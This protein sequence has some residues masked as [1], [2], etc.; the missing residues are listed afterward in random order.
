MDPL[1]ITAGV[2]GGS[3]SHQQSWARACKYS[4]RSEMRLVPSH[5]SQLNMEVADL[6]LV[7][8]AVDTDWFSPRNQHNPSMTTAQ[9]PMISDALERAKR[10]MLDVEVLIKRSLIEITDT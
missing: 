4:W 6:Q 8:Q 3:W 10:A 2:F 7:V 1:S 9:S 5:E